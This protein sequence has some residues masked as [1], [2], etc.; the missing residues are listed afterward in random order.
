MNFKKL[1]LFIAFLVL[2]NAATADIFTIV[3]TDHGHIVKVRIQGE[4][5]SGFK[6]YAEDIKPADLAYHQKAFANATMMRNFGTG[7]PRTP[8]YTETRVRAW[9]KRFDDG[10]PHGGLTIFCAETNQPIGHVVAGGGDDEGVSETAY[11]LMEHDWDEEGE[12]SLWGQGIMSNVVH[13][14]VTDWAQEVRRLGVDENLDPKVK[15]AF[16]CFG[17]KSLKRI[18]ATASPANPASWRLLKRNGFE[19]ARIQNDTGGA[20]GAENLLVE[21]DL[22]GLEGPELEKALLTLF[23]GDNALEPGKRYQVNVPN[24]GLFTFSFKERFGRIKFH[25]ELYLDEE[26]GDI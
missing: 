1:F 11:T 6:W 13:T 4:T 7:E 3:Q 24:W 26:D 12:P 20:A 10:Y 9:R 14:I 23:E 5:A 18:D 19:P 8:E 21:I 17:G 2:T 22:K 15:E 16:C 25:F